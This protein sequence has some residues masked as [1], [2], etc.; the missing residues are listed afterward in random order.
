MD[1]TTTVLS[2]KPLHIRVLSPGFDSCAETEYFR[3]V[4]AT[5]SIYFRSKTFDS[6]RLVLGFSASWLKDNQPFLI[7]AILDDT[8]DQKVVFKH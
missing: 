8:G 6:C 5:S 1:Y 2:P 7:G 4:V 3:I